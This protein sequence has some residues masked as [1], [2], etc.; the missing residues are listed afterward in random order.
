MSNQA[1][2]CQFGSLCFIRQKIQEPQTP[3]QSATN[4][5]SARLGLVIEL[6]RR[7]TLTSSSLSGRVIFT[8][9]FVQQSWSIDINEI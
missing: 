6:F 5:S 4:P 7:V 2:G 8:T 1:K 9:Y 3:T